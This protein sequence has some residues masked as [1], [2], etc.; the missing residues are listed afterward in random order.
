MYLTSSSHTASLNPTSSSPIHSLAS[1]PTAIC[2]P[3][4][5][6]SKDDNTCGTTDIDEPWRASVPI[7]ALVVLVVSGILS[8]VYV[9]VFRYK[10][11][12]LQK[13]VSR[14]RFEKLDDRMEQ[15]RNHECDIRTTLFEDYFQQDASELVQIRDLQNTTIVS[16]RGA[17]NQFAEGFEAAK[18]EAYE[19]S[20]RGF[21][22]RY[23]V[24][25]S[26][27]KRKRHGE[28]GPVSKYS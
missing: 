17:T 1:L 10:V 27:I 2:P 26:Q 4:N 15:L 28:F 11:Y 5:S 14:L 24:E 23:G 3:Q 13:N 9:I 18:R 7:T 19:I 25:P 16:E 8:F 12:K 6:T 22:K 21:S 20:R